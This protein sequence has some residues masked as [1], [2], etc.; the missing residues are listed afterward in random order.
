MRSVGLKQLKNRLSEYIRLVGTGETVLITDRDRVIAEIVPPRADR[1][2]FLGDAMLAG[3]VRNG[4]ITPPAL[5]GNDPPP[6]LPVAPLRDILRG[7]RE[8]RDAR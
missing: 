5:P 1:S 3:A 4:W 2:Q 7:P 6:R 8:D